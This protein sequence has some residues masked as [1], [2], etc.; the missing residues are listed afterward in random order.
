MK[1]LYG[2]FCILVLTSSYASIGP[3]SLDCKGDLFIP[4][5]ERLNF[6]PLGS[7]LQVMHSLEIYSSFDFSKLKRDGYFPD[8]IPRDPV[9]YYREVQIS[10][11]RITN[12]TFLWEMVRQL[13]LKP[14]WTDETEEREITEEELQAF[15]EEVKSTVKAVGIVSGDEDKNA[16]KSGGIAGKSE[17]RNA[18]ERDKNRGI[19][20]QGRKVDEGIVNDNE[21]EG[22]GNAEV[23]SGDGGMES[24]KGEAHKQSEENTTSEYTTARTIRRGGYFRQMERREEV[25]SLM[26]KNN[27]ITAAQI[28]GILKVSKSTV[29]QDIIYLR[30]DLNNLQKTR[31]IRVGSRNTSVNGHWHIIEKGVK[32]SIEDFYEQRKKK[33][34]FLM[35]RNP[36][37]KLA[38]L[39]K[40]L[41]VSVPTISIIIRELKNKG[42][43]DKDKETR[44]WIPRLTKG[45]EEEFEASVL[46]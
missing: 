32:F 40:E 15:M 19:R 14:E 31:I 27:Q 2:I 29:D 43:L 16:R 45:E 28:V 36:Y 39:A 10:S 3:N 5:E 8:G 11:D 13:K 4:D 21:K 26:R 23:E 38:E 25:I 41:E 44:A 22:A 33:M 9:A 18:E 7:F 6:A 30:E 24:E 34:L 1:S 20:K 37:I 17:V 42:R 46:T 12:W 35:W